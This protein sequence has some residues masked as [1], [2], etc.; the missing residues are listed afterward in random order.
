LSFEIF[1]L[2]D[3]QWFNF[4]H[5]SNDQIWAIFWSLLDSHNQ[6]SFWLSQGLR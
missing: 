6:M 1:K 2:F 3:R 4:H 5:W